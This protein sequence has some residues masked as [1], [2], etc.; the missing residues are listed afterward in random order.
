V[1]FIAF[2]RRQLQLIAKVGEYKLLRY[3]AKKAA[4]KKEEK[5]QPFDHGVKIMAF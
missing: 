1:N 2:L 3:A 4:C 5:S